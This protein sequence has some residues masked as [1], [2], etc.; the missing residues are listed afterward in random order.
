MSMEPFVYI[1]VFNSAPVE[2]WHFFSDHIVFELVPNA[3]N[4]RTTDASRALYY[5]III[6][7]II[8]F[9]MIIKLGT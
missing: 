4:I 8:I 9:L 7:I 6:I 3:I 2:R 1:V 5:I